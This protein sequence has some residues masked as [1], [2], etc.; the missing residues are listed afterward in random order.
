MIRTRIVT[1][2]AFGVAFGLARGL[3]AQNESAGPSRFHEQSEALL[4]Q[5]P[6]WVADRSGQPLRGLTASDFEVEDEGVRQLIDAADTVDL[7]ERKLREAPE[8][9]W[10]PPERR[11]FLLLFDLS[12]AAPREVLRSRDAA[13]SFVSQMAPDDRAGISTISVEHG[14][15]LLLTFTSDRRQLIAAIG[16]LGSTAVVPTAEDPLAMAFALPGDPH[17]AKMFVG[18]Q[19]APRGNSD[20]SSTTKVLAM[21]ARKSGDEFASAQV[22]RQ[23]HGLSALAEAMDLVP[24]RKI[25]VYFSEGFD[26][27]LLVGNLHQDPAETSAENDAMTSGQF[28]QIDVDKR[29]SNTP[30]QRQ[31]S[32]TLA[33]FRRSD[34]VIYPIDIGGLKAEGDVGIGSLRHGEDALFTIAAATGGE[35]IPNAN[36]VSAALRRI[37]E[38]TSVTYI[39]SFRPSRRLPEG[40]FHH[41]KVRCRAK[42]ARVSARSGYFERKG[43]SHMGPLERS[44]SAAQI[45]S[46]NQNGGVAM[47]VL[48]LPIRDEPLGQV[49]VVIEVPQGAFMEARAKPMR[50]GIYV[51]ALNERQEVQDFFSRQISRSGIAADQERQVFRYYGTLR[52]LPGHYS[53]RA[54]V[55]DE[56]SGRFGYRTA[57]LNLEAP[58]TTG[59]ALLSPLFVGSPESG[60]GVRAM[61]EEGAPVREPFSL[62]GNS[63]IPA[64]R[65]L[66]RTDETT[67]VCLLLYDSGRLSTAADLGIDVNVV[68]SAHRSFVPEAFRLLG[69]TAADQTGLVKLLAEFQPG[70]LPPGDYEL[71]VR[72][73]RSGAAG[74]TGATGEETSA[75]FRIR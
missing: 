21:T 72:W 66:L 31:L 11:N 53:I 26:A 60:V 58:G 74:A 57:S 35:V 2:V 13:A 28:W 52:L 22:S 33:F 27:R 59:P 71:C 42:G 18:D 23:L 7:Q 40:A 3:S 1:V 69:R 30:L 29:Y 36:D 6:V 49:P 32:E 12:F 8:A 39:L 62:S 38:R 46:G 64:L 41:L 15:H 63:F 65:P 73:K 50:L 5:V 44:L 4:V 10:T 54:L 34:C 56:D 61:R 20:I 19:G 24:G 75:P 51:Y 70:N 14:A 43:F 55:R 17:L 45:V 47:D 9:G 67:R 16:S 37:S 48:V 25:V 68:D